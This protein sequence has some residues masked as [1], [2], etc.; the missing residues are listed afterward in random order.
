MMLSLCELRLGNQAIAMQ[1][2]DECI[3][4]YP[5]HSDAFLAKA[6][7]LLKTQRYKAC[8]NVL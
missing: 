5:Q 4:K 7:L 3:D 8:L 2:L 1:S 6:I